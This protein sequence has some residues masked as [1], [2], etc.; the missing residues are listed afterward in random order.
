M[1]SGGQVIEQVY[2]RKARR[3]VNN[4][5]P[6]TAT[7]EDYLEVILNIV[8][9]HK[10]ARSMEIAEKLNVRRPTVTVALRALAEKG[11]INYTPRSYITLTDQGEK[12]AQCVDKRH[13]VLRD[14]FTDVLML[15]EEE[16]EEAACRMEH[17]MNT[18]VCKSVMSLLRAAEKDQEFAGALRGAVE[19]E[20]RTIDCDQSCGY[21]RPGKDNARMTQEPLNLNMLGEGEKGNVVRIVGDG[22]LKRRLREMGITAGLPVTVIKSAPLKD[23]I[24]IRI[25]NCNMSLRREEAKNI[26]VER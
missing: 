10:V 11:L 21:T 9:K 26:L 19:R 1:G 2:G 7:L 24:E 23:P 14:F 20:K 16:A 4:A 18:E 22:A 6:L 5:I 3:S 25:R 8:S 13:H 17:G 15:Q 12:I